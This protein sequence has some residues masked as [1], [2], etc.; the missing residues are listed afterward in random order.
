MILSL[1]ILL[2]YVVGCTSLSYQPCIH[3]PK[4]PVAGRRTHL[5]ATCWE[6]CMVALQARQGRPF[7]IYAA[8][9]RGTIK[10]GLRILCI[11]VGPSHAGV[12]GHHLGSHQGCHPVLYNGRCLS[13]QG[14]L[15]TLFGPYLLLAT[16]P[17]INHPVQRYI[18]MALFCQ[19]TPQYIRCLITLEKS[20]FTYR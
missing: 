6:A 16:H 10:V 13:T 20:L 4:D 19:Q 3:G 2:C 5:S 12:C 14:L 11:Y 18:S 9:K 15:P 7:V 17:H 8:L 1:Y